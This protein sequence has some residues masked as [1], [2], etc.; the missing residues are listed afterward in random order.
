MLFLRAKQKHTNNV[1]LGPQ[2]NSDPSTCIRE[3]FDL[4]DML[5]L[6]FPRPPPPRFEV[7]GTQRQGMRI[8]LETIQEDATRR[9]RALL[10]SIL[11]I[12][13][14]LEQ[15]DRWRASPL[16]QSFERHLYCF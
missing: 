16:P 12:A 10:A 11:L 3:S 9:Q 13:G 14:P 2:R 15:H 7:S 8:V 5:R 6:E 4:E 1:V